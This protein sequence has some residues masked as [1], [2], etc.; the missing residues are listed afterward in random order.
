MSF[1]ENH[2]ILMDGQYGFISNQ[3]ISLTLTEFVV[4]VIS[5]I[6]KREST[7]GVFIDLEK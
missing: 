3:S 2:H 4:K 6:D 5:A 1:I 7:I